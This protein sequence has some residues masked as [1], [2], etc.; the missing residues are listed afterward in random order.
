MR[1]IKNK[2][3]IIK[4]KHKPSREDQIRRATQVKPKPNRP[5]KHG[6]K[7]DSVTPKLRKKPRNKKHSKGGIH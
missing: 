2:P 6:H 5:V 3:I 7:S 1:P 4:E